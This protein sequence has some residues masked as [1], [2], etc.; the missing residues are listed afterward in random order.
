V[1]GRTIEGD[2]QQSRA[3]HNLAILIVKGSQAGAFKQFM[4]CTVAFNLQ[5]PSNGGS[6]TLP[7]Q[8]NSRIKG[9]SIHIV[10]I[11]AVIAILRLLT[12]DGGG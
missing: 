7:T 4:Y 3:I 8:R 9:G 1:R 12:K 6:A 11:I 5:H 10:A 2:F